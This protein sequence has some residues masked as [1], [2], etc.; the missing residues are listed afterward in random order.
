MT[1]DAGSFEERLSYLET[2][3]SEIEELRI[4]LS[5]LGET[6]EH[7]LVVLGN[8]VQEHPELQERSSLMDSYNRI[9][10]L[11]GELSALLR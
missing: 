8:L 6:L 3:V 11:V 5:M 1:D 4:N 7:L 9:G 10:E 2:R